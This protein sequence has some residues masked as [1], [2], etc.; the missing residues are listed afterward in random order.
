MYV[1]THNNLSNFKTYYCDCKLL[2]GYIF[3]TKKGFFKTLTLL[4]NL[5]LVVVLV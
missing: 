5:L 3:K 4:A 1:H 2:V